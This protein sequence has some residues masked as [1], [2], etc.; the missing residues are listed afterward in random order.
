MSPIKRGARRR[1][2]A[3]TA[4]ATM[5][6][7]PLALSTSAQAQDPDAQ[8]ESQ[9][10]AGSYI[11]QLKSDPLSIYEGG[12]QSIPATKPGV[13]DK[14][15]VG[16]SASDRYLDFLADERAGVLSDAGI[17]SEA[18]AYTYDVALN[19]FSA[20]LSAGQ[21]AALRKSDAVVNVWPNEV[22]YADTV[23]TP[24]YLGLTGETG[25]WDTQ[26]GGQSSAGED[27]IVGVIDTGIAMDNPSFAP[28]EDATIPDGVVCDAGEEDGFECNNK[29]IGARYYP[30]G[31]TIID[32]EVLSPT[33]KNGHGSH[34][35]GTA[36]GNGDVP[37]SVAGYDLGVGSGMA[38]RAQIIAYKALWNTEDD[39]GTGNSDALVA[40]IDDATSDGVDV[41]NYSVSGSRDFVVTPDEIAFLNAATNGIF[42][43]TSAGNS[44]ADVGPS[45]VAHNSPWTTTVAASTHDRGATKTL[46]LYSEDADNNEGDT[47]D[48]VGVG[49]ALDWSSFVPSTDVGAEGASAT[50]V[51]E[52]WLDAD[53]DTEGVQPSLDPSLAEGAIVMCDR[54]TVARTD[55]SAAVALAGGAGMVLANTTAA[56]SLDADFHSVPTIHVTS[57]T[58]TALLAYLDTADEGVAAAKISA[59]N[60]DPVVAPEMAGF[61]SFGPA[62]AG[63]GDLLKPD[64]TAPG[65]NIVAAYHDDRET[66]EPAF[67]SISGTSMSAPHIAGLGALMK[68]KYPE[69]S[70][71]AIKSAMMTTARDVNTAGDPIER[72]GEAASPLDYG[73]GE[74]V[75]GESYNAGLVYDADAADYVGY[76]CSIQQWQLV[77]GDCTDFEGADPSDSNYPSVSIGA[78]A[79][80]QTVTRTVTNVTDSEQTV[81]ATTEAPEGMSVSVSPE[82]MT[83]DSGDTATFDV[84]VTAAGAPVGEWAFGSYTLGNDSINVESPVAVLPTAV[85]FPEEVYETTTSGSTDLQA[86]TAADTEARFVVDGLEPATVNEVEVTRDPGTV[87]DYIGFVSVPEGASVLQVSTFNEGVSA[88]D[89]DL[90]LYYPD[91]SFA[92]G[93]GNGDSNEQVRLVNPP[94]GEY[95]ITIDVF[96]DVPTATVELNEWVLEFDSAADNMTVDP[97]TASTVA[98][99]PTD[100]TLEWSD[101]PAGV[102]HLGAVNYELDG[103]SEGTTVVTI[104][105]AAEVQRLSGANRFATAAEVALSYPAEVDTVYLV[106]GSAFADALSG[107]SPAAQSQGTST[108]AVDG[109]AA[110]ILLTKA[111]SLPPETS[112]ALETLAPANIV[113]L[114][115]TGAVSQSIQD[116]L[117]ADATVVR[118]GGANRYETSANVAMDLYSPGVDTVYVASGQD[119]NFADALSGGALAGYEGAPVLLTRG[120]RALTETMEALD[121]LAPTNVVVLGGEAAVSA[122]V[123]TAVGG[124]DRLAGA[125][126]YETGVAITAA[127]DADQAQAYIASGLAWPDALAGAALAGY[128]GAPMLLTETDSVPTTVMDELDRLSPA[129]VTIL[130]GTA[131]VSQGVEDALNVPL[132]EWAL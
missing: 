21:V 11:V 15:D 74:V 29:V 120:D 4:A 36:A 68:Q 71:A 56:Q 51:A 45:S 119:S 73:S 13:G 91:G 42:V 87:N 23:G 103:T 108:M 117:S 86:T 125:D 83:I 90:N 63:G 96:S 112:D 88:D 78:L 9:D 52:C 70:P 76:A 1:A 84:T 93:S 59:Q 72:N 104:D 22:R 60:T 16:S 79:G 80:S 111:D 62:I 132:P 20:E 34:T 58:R 101:I 17:N 14:V 18:I 46:T 66:G 54:G 19:G 124:T 57:T 126:R 6:V 121:Y 7:A 110:P 94:A 92:A 118:I 128:E 105:P 89:I 50:A 129:G 48:G 102:R 109:S 33:D 2:I 35:A 26:F 114:G 55:K 39:Q 131:V 130:G 67:N 47:Y 24:E 122:D 41:I 49:D 99:E 116:E 77:G 38:P 30:E 127:Y 44:G 3:A 97:T 8:L 69:W 107:A 106:S 25:V 85:S 123:Y 100:I 43:A 81:N 37:M 113:I 40:A 64:I 98:G 5:V 28:M 27:V 32:T 53:P 61:S 115:G 95:F 10:E 82:S 31:N 65:A 75:P 12:I